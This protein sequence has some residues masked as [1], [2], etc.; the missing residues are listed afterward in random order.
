MFIVKIVRTLKIKL[1]LNQED[2]LMIDKTLQA[3]LDGL[4]YASKIAYDNGEITNKFKLQKIVYNDLRTKFNL[5]SQMA[6]N[7]CTVV[8]GSYATQHSNKTYNKY[9]LLQI[10]IF[11][12]YKHLSLKFCHNYNNQINQYTF[13]FLQ[14]LEI[15]LYLLMDKR[16][17]HK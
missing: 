4:N 15:R 14:K 12:L 10:H 5:K 13:D 3:F 1:N 17:F 9:S 7:I 11:L 2:I 16:L 8:C 6:V